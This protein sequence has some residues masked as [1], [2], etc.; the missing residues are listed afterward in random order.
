MPTGARD[1]R[2]R[3]RDAVLDR[4]SM[5][6]YLGGAAV[7]LPLAACADASAEGP[8][9][10]IAYQQFGSGE[11]MANYLTSVSEQ[12]SS[13]HPE[14]AVELVPIVAAE[15]DY[16]TK[17]ELMMSSERTCPDLVYEDTFILKA[18]VE[19]GYLRQIDDYI[20]GWEVWDEFFDPAKEAVTG[21]D[22]GIYAVP[23]HTDTR[24]LW[25]HSEAFEDAGLETPWEPD[26]WD[27]LL[28]TLRELQEAHGDE[29]IPFNIFSGKPQGEKAS[30]QGFQ[31][32]LYGTESTLYDE[33]SG[34]WIV[35]SQGFL[36]SLEFLR[37][38]FT[39]GLTPGMG[40]ALDPNLTE[41]VY[42]TWLP[43]GTLAVNLD[44]SWISADWEEGAPGE[45][46]D[47]L[48]QMQL[49]TMPTQHGDDP[50]FVTLSGGWSWAIP[51]LASEPD[52][53]WEF[54]QQM[55][56][57]DN[58]TELAV[59][60]NQVTIRSDVA[61]RSEYQGY[62]PTIEFFTDLVP[63]AIYRPAYAPYPQISAAIQA[64][65]ETVMTG[66]GSPEEAAAT[67]DG[68]VRNIVGDDA[69][70]TET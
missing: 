42:S 16:F 29:V 53:A 48:D 14:V 31:M 46:P 37:T 26:T 40:H 45:W 18:D 5:I 64:A 9:L 25:Y 69:V 23:T 61:A 34:L 10:R 4:R 62:S 50:G 15:H 47:W 58:M 6:R 32:L 44:G 63:D 22:G 36:D 24:A 35:G 67:Y 2:R 49:A 59:I 3:V 21:D 1:E 33:E 43:E 11:T 8:R 51:R 20:D 70:G 30:M 12:F 68:A 52:L 19:A 65:M 41:T 56:T 13:S 7:V 55:M 60:D 27:A 66:Q 17:N 28:E 39:E 38:V 57:E 54:L